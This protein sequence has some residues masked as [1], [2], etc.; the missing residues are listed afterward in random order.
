MD[1]SNTPTQEGQVTSIKI[2]YTPSCS[3]WSRSQ[4][5]WEKVHSNEKTR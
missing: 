4:L 5:T 1:A 3:A 2:L